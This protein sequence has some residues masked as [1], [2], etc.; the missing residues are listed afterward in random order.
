MILRMNYLT[1]QAQNGSTV[2]KKNIAQK[3]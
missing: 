3:I 1:V 2:Q